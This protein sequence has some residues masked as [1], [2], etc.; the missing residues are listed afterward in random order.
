M[1]GFKTG[2][3][4]RSQNVNVF[5]VAS[6]RLGSEVPWK[7]RNPSSVTDTQD[8]NT[9]DTFAMWYDV[10]AS[11]IEEAKSTQES[12]ATTGVILPIHPYIP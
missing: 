3:Y 10:K 4:S 1:R 11:T 2:V 5:C 7:G 6:A 12:T 8:A 9:I